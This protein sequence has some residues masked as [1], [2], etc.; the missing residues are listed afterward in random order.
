MPRLVVLTGGPGA[1]KTAALEVVRKHFGAAVEVLPESAGIIF[2]GGFPRRATPAARRAAQRAIFR[3]Q[4]ELERLACDES[5]AKLVLCDRG[6][7]DGL[8]YWPDDSDDL[9]A[10]VGVRR[11]DEVARY[12]L[13]IHMRPPAAGHGFDHS[14]PLRIESALQSATVDAGIER[15]WAGHPRRVVVASTDVFL[16]KVAEVTALVEA[17]LAAIASAR[18]A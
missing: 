8:A 11:A 14:N 7:L 16:D 13:V 10:D 3:V 17:E 6:T 2:G 5:T 9:L 12:A 18:S 15:A 1:G 4:R